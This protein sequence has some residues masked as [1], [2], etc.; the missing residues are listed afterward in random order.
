MNNLPTE[1]IL[2][3][4]EKVKYVGDLRKFMRLNK[5]YHNIISH[6]IKRADITIFKNQNDLFKS[7]DYYDFD[8]TFPTSIYY[9][10]IEYVPEC[11]FNFK[12]LKILVIK[13][14]KIQNFQNFLNL[15]NLTLLSINDIKLEN[16]SNLEVF[17]KLVQLRL[18]DNDLNQVLNI[19][20]LNSLKR[21]NI[22]K[23]IV[24]IKKFPISIEEISIKSEILYCPD[25]QNLNNLANLILTNG[26]LTELPPLSN[27]IKKLDLSNNK[28]ETLHINLPELYD[29]DV[30][31]NKLKHLQLNCEKL[32]TLNI[33][34]NFLSQFQLIT[35]DV[36]FSIFMQNNLIEYLPQFVENFKNL[37]IIKLDSINM[38]TFDYKKLPKLTKIVDNKEVYKINK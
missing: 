29:L 23:N 30:S 12:S 34:N 11:L 21:I 26:N 37:A 5:F 17:T 3:I 36:I 19:S 22:E 33:S 7:Y 14:N 16:V 27:S 32:L 4:F 31:N 8:M 24:E 15:T 9:L 13:C 20:D 6:I 10:Q 25:L 2:E 28:F 1:L 18:S 35:G 38:F